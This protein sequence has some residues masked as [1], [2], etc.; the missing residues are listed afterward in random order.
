MLRNEPA[1]TFKAGTGT[2]TSTGLVPARD[3]L[4]IT[5]VVPVYRSAVTLP[6]LH[7]RI[8]SS[9]ERITKKFEII[10][11]EDCGDDNSW[12]VIQQLARLDFRVRGIKLSRNF[13]QH[14]ATICGCSSASGRWIFTLDDDLEH[15]PEFIPELYEKAIQ[16]FSLV[17]GVYPQRTHNVWRNITSEIGRRMFR[18]AIP[19]LNYSYTSFRCIQGE[20]AREMV[21][22][23]SPFPFVDGYLSWITNNCAAVSIVHAERVSGKSNYNFRKLVVH[24]INIFV[25]FSD[26]PLRLASWLGLGAF[27][28]GMLWLAT[29][30]IGKLLGNITVSGFA[31]V[32]AGIVLFGGI[33]LLILGIIGEYLGRVN[34]KTSRRPLYLIARDTRQPNRDE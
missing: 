9:V 33:Q 14:A 2:G 17:Y 34:F 5:V 24:S 10:L 27:L 22:F 8:V 11:V 21:R 26:L 7:R 6:E 20:L 19:S 13:G 29:I 16:G 30:I 25:T 12:D 1:A 32:M 31:S 28:V 15:Q 4:E 23:D 18:L 3:E